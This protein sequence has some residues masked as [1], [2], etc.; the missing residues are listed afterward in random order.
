MTVTRLH[1]NSLSAALGIEVFELG[2]LNSLWEN[3]T[4]SKR[5]ADVGLVRP[6]TL[7]CTV[8]GSEVEVPW[9]LQL[10][11]PI[12]RPLSSSDC[13]DLKCEENQTY[14]VYLKVIRER[15]SPPCGYKSEWL[16][17]CKRIIQTGFLNWTEWFIERI[18]LCT[19]NY[20]ILILISTIFSFKVPLPSSNTH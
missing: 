2:R 7:F 16:L 18:W 11:W 3:A 12:V 9:S 13:R 1:N 15:Y 14:K 8:C 6:S 17:I 4:V 5:S 20:P 10:F 19:I